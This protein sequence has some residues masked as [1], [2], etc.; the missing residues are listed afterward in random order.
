M[1]TS[2]PSRPSHKGAT[3][4]THRAAEERLAAGRAL[5]DRV[6]RRSHGDWKPAA[7]RPDPIAV[8]E[9]QAETRLPQYVPIRHG[10]MVS[11]PFAFL[12]GSAAIMAADL[13]ST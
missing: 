12:R 13:A 5:R 7:N 11:S 4:P 8:L 10:R 3:P 1:K 2:R 9:K 6:S